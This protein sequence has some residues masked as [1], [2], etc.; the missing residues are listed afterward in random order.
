MLNKFQ[1]APFE[2]LRLLP[3]TT[4]SIVL[5]I[6]GAMV[7]WVRG[8]TAQQGGELLFFGSRGRVGLVDG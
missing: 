7:I 5:Y 1:L 3:S 8:D 6:S 4:F 2:V